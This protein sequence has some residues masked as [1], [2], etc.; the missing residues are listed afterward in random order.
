[1]V[2]VFHYTPVNTI[3]QFDELNF[4]GLAGKRQKHQNFPCQSFA[5]FGKYLQLIIYWL[6]Y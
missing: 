4:D 3:L 5:L 2:I 1:M 6:I